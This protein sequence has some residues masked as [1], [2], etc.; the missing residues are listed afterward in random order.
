MSVGDEVFG[1]QTLPR[2]R[3]VNGAYAEYVIADSADLAV[4]PAHISHDEA[5]AVPQ[6]SPAPCPCGR[7]VR[8]AAPTPP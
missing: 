1:R 7:G 3:E 5:A 8:R 4:K 2:M 6:A